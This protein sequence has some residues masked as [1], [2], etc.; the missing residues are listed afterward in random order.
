MSAHAVLL[1]SC[2]DQR[3]IVAAVADFVAG[4]DG[5]IIHAEQH[6]D[7]LEGV[8]FQRVEFDL[9]GFALDRHSIL[10]AFRP[11]AARFGMAAEL[12][13]T[14]E[15]PRVAI[16][17]SKQPHCLVDLLT[18][19]RTGDLFGEVVVVIANHPDHAALCAHLGVPYA[20]LPVDPADPPAQ[21]RALLAELARHDLDL[22]V[23]ARYM[24]ILSPPP[25]SPTATG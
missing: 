5:N 11:V 6:V 14:D 17:A 18:R 7:E 24:R 19:W 2:P 16:L 8:F 23:L 22:V 3:G 4:H 15:P 25:S 10:E 21:E 1:L 20:H 12:H 9:D 13:V